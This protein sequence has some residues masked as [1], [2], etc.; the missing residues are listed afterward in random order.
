MT[1]QEY[2]QENV[3]IVYHGGAVEKLENK[4][5]YFSFDKNFA[6]SYAKIKGGEVKKY[7]VTINNPASENDIKQAIEKAGM[8]KDSNLAEIAS[9]E[10]II[11]ILRKKGFDGIYDVSDFGFDSDFDEYKILMVFNASEQVE[12]YQE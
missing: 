6:N 3:F 1:F 2:L 11:N 8:D 4:P 9:D 10:K 5:M 12:I 7:K